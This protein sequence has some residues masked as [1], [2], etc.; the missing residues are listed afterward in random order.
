MRLNDIIK[1]HKALALAASASNPFEAEAAAAGVRRLVKACNLDP[2]RIPDVSYV[3]HINFKDNA[4]LKQ[5]RDEWREAYPKPVNT[6][7]K[8]KPGN[9]KPVNTSKLK[10]PTDDVNSPFADLSFADFSFADFEKEPVNTKR[11]RDRHSPGYMRDYMRRRRA[12]QRA[13]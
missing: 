8:A 1:F 5:L 10:V 11:N 9:T 12:T 13:G 6:K 4:L 7:P 3:A 2:T